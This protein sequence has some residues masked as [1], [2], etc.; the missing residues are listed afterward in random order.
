MSGGSHLPS[1][2]ANFGNDSP[3][4]PVATNRI[5]SAKYLNSAS[6]PPLPPKRDEALSREQKL[7][8]QANAGPH[9]SSGGL[10]PGQIIP[11]QQMMKAA[12]AV[13]R[14]AALPQRKQS[15]MPMPSPSLPGTTSSY[16]ANTSAPQ[17]PNIPQRP[18][19]VE[20]RVH[21][22]DSAFMPSSASTATR[23]MQPSAH[24]AR[25]ASEQTR[26]QKAGYNQQCQHQAQP[27]A[28]EKKALQSTPSLNVVLPDLDALGQIRER[29]WA[30]GSEKRK[31]AWCKEVI[32]YVER[33]SEGTKISEPTLIRYIDESMGCI[34]R[35]ASSQ[36]PLVESLYLRGDLLASGAFPTYHRKNPK[37]AFNDFELSARMGYAPSWFRIGRDYE[38]LE[39]V[40][41]ARD[42]YERGCAVKDVGCIYRMGMANLLSQ[43]NIPMNH[44]KAIPLMREAANLANLDTPQPAF[45]YGMLLTGEFKHV[46]V[47]PSLLV[48]MPDPSRPSQAVTLEAEACRRIQRAAYLNFGPAQ[49]KCGWSYEYAQLGCS[50]DPLLSVQF[51]S[52]ASQSGEVEADLA[53]S[54]WFLCGAEGCFDKNEALAFTFA[55]KAARKGLPSAEFAMGYYFDVGIGCEKNVE[56][57][58]RWYR[59]S[60]K[61]GNKDAIERLAALEGPTPETL[62][63]RQHEV[64]V[65]TQLVR[66]RTEAKMKSDRKIRVARKAI[67]KEDGNDASGEPFKGQLMSSELPK[68]TMDLRRRD[69]M[70]MVEETARR[71]PPRAK[72][73]HNTDSWERRESAPNTSR[74]PPPHPPKLAILT[75]GSGPTRMPSPG[76]QASRRPSPGPGPSSSANQRP[77]PPSP[78]RGLNNNNKNVVRG[79]D[80][81]ARPPLPGHRTSAPTPGAGLTDSIPVKAPTNTSPTPMYETFGEMGFSSAKAKEDKDCI[82]C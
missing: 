34:N 69:T 23:G 24:P 49:Y 4:P 68:P 43:L 8:Q 38:L 75:S 78:A 48:P 27:E 5:P 55:E 53:L 15:P 1:L 56:V 50:F 32:K 14:P 20:P 82:I 74:P 9:I 18:R 60:A 77:P 7:R 51:Y 72:P 64:H 29:A 6:A 65:D 46:E 79:K 28:E 21:Q 26:H 73:V 30:S 66:K 58:Q 80:S 54:K 70:M 3:F 81:P 41:R 19:T 10:R 76:P 31:L 33:K 47:S 37:A 16:Q 39:D 45:I 71:G 13:S 52:L 11:S 59:K 61:N 25:G 42:A 63:R 35:I 36:S 2:P 22:S 44:N 40:V 57:A 17:P 12:A 62:S 67:L